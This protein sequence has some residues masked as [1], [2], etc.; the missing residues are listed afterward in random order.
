MSIETCAAICRGQ[1]TL[2]PSVTPELSAPRASTSLHVSR[3][4][5]RENGGAAA[6]RKKSTLRP[7][8]TPFDSFAARLEQSTN[9]RGAW[10]CTAVRR[11]R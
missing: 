1:S 5:E 6:C 4:N 2:H 10:K 11:R 3:T 9:E 8:V 7:S